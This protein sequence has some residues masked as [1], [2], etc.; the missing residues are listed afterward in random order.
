MNPIDYM[1]GIPIVITD[2]IKK[3]VRKRK[4]KK[5]RIDKKWEKQYGYKSVTD[6]AKCIMFNGTIYMSQKCYENVKKAYR[7]LEEWQNARIAPT[8][9]ICLMKTM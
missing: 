7:R 9:I 8:Y 1:S 2:A 6:D 3:D 4:H 5:K